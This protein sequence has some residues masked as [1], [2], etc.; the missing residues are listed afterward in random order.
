MISRQLIENTP[1]FLQLD[2]LK[3]VNKGAHTHTHTYSA[4]PV[5]LTVQSGMQASS[6]GG[7]PH[8]KKGAAE[9]KS[10]IIPEKTATH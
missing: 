7:L 2:L 1:C 8:P 10:V 4:S 3:K 6:C 5:G 9:L